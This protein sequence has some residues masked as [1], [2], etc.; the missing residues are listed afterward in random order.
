MSLP[1]RISRCVAGYL[2]LFKFNKCWQVGKCWQVSFSSFPVGVMNVLKCYVLC[3][4]NEGS[5]PCLPNI[6]L[7]PF[8]VLREG[9]ESECLMN[10][11]SKRVTSF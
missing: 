2:H 6:P 5:S 7:V 9:N 3:Y 10:C 1:L 11:L 8:T 4:E